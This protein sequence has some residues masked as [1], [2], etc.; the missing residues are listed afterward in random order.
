MFLIDLSVLIPHFICLCNE[1][2]SV[3]NVYGDLLFWTWGQLYA[4]STVCTWFFVVYC[5]KH[6]YVLSWYVL[7]PT[8]FLSFMD[9]W[10]V[11]GASK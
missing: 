2:F 1:Y 3:R 4:D 6:V 8:G 5:Y 11:G 10:N 7:Y 9:L